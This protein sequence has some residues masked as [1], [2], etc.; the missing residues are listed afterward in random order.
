MAQSSATVVCSADKG[1]LH[2]SSREIAA[3]WACWLWAAEC[4]AFLSSHLSEM[5]TNGKRM[6]R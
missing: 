3:R 1:E 4:S 5:L 6:G 2:D